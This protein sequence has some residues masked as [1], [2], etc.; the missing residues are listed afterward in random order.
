MRNPSLEQK[1]RLLHLMSA[2]GIGAADLGLPGAGDRAAADRGA[3]PGDRS[4]PS[5]ADRP[6]C[7][8]RTTDEDLL[9]TLEISS[10]SAG[11]SR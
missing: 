9:P 2:L 6:A 3:V 5:A 4:R 8:A 1:I 11:R 7:A 10:G